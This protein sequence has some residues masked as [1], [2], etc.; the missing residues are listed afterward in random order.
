MNS[1]SEDSKVHL[2]GLV[3]GGEGV[4]GKLDH[5]ANTGI[6][7]SLSGHPAQPL[8]VPTQYGTVSVCQVRAVYEEEQLNQRTRESESNKEAMK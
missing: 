3:T 1:G 7:L 5:D 2:W 6:V 4:V 8:L